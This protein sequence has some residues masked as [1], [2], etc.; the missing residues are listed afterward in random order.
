MS[1]S[2][3]S[4]TSLP[5]VC[6]A[7][8]YYRHCCGSQF[9]IGITLSLSLLPSSTT[10]S[11]FLP[12]RYS[13]EVVL[14]LCRKFWPSCICTWQQRT[15]IQWKDTLH[16]TCCLSSLKKRKFSPLYLFMFPTKF[17]LISDTRKKSIFC[18][19][20]VCLSPFSFTLDAVSFNYFRI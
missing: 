10:N 14:D 5:F 16:Y 13:D 3:I 18:D 15:E 19:M 17:Y 2:N 1:V 4:F 8:I 11:S 6:M 7:P 9:C 12:Q 20:K